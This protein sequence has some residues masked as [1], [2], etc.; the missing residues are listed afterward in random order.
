M[1]SSLTVTLT[2][3]K[4]TVSGGF[5]GKWRGATADRGQQSGCWQLSCGVPQRARLAGRFHPSLTVAVT[6]GGTTFVTN[7]YYP[8]FSDAWTP[9][10]AARSR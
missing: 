6:N 8:T 10:A 9:T 5:R 4:R 1:N 7:Q 2:P 3:P